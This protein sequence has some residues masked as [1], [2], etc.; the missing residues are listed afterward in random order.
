MRGQ[1]EGPHLAGII[2]PA[3]AKP[4]CFQLLTMRG[5]E[6]ITAV[7]A[8][9]PL[10]AA[11]SVAQPTARREMD[12]AGFLHERA[13]Q[14]SND[15]RVGLRIALGVVRTPETGDVAGKFKE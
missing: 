11:A 8:L 3:E 12:H 6:S 14:G 9:R 5:V 7:V 13:V 1:F 4:G 15:K 2:K 10:V